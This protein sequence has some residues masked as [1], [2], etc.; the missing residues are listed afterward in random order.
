MLLVGLVAADADNAAPAAPSRRRADSPPPR[1][2]LL[3]ALLLPLLALPSLT[4]A[5]CRWLVKVSGEVEEGAIIESGRTQTAEEGEESGGG[6][7]R[8]P[9]APPRLLVR[10]GGCFS[11]NDGADRGKLEP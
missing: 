2:L 4:T 3:L 6:R 1:A 5:P 7:R 8:A 9:L 10:A 11:V